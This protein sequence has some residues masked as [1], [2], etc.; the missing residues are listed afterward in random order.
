MFKELERN[1][2]RNGIRKVCNNL[3]K[4]RKNDMKHIPLYDL[5]IFYGLEPLIQ[6]FN[7][8]RVEF[9]G[10]NLSGAICKKFCQIANAGANFKYCLFII[11][12]CGFN[13]PVQNPLIAQ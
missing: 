12:M 5:D 11:Q 1:L 8:P 10:N 7:K 13:N 3:V 2:G 9:Y 4:L 6:Y